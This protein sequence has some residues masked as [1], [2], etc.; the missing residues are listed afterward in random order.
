MSKSL[1]RN[2]IFHSFWSLKLMIIL[3]ITKMEGWKRKKKRNCMTRDPNFGYWRKSEKTYIA[4][5]LV[6][7]I[8]KEFS[9]RYI[10]ICVYIFFL[11]ILFPGIVAK[12]FTL[13]IQSTLEAISQ[14]SA[15]RLHSFESLVTFT[16]WGQCISFPYI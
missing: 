3:K 15:A 8:L 5:S 16:S 14:H 6:C 12:Q 1:R 10:N 4:C 13:D 9:H 11:N 7:V 2:K